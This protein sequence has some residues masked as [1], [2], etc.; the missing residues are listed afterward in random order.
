MA[1][2]LNVLDFGCGTGYGTAMLAKEASSVVGVDISEEALRWANQSHRNPKL[3][4]D[5]RSDLAEGLPDS[6][7]DL[8]TCFE[9][10]E[11]VDQETQKLV[12]KN[13]ID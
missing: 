13:F 8:V 5:C 12:I 10:I 1:K 2:G 9:M 6:S 3:R 7:V 4:F 11:H